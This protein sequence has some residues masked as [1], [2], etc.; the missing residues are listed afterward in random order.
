MMLPGLR[1]RC[2]MPAAWAAA[3]ASA[4]SIGNRRAPDRP[5][6]ARVANARQRLAVHQL[7]HQD[8]ARRRRRSAEP[9]SCSVQMC[10]CVS[11]AMARA[12]RS[13]RSRPLRIAGS[14]ARQNL[15]RHVAIEP[16]VARPVDLAHA[17]GAEQ[18]EHF[19][20][21]SRLRGAACAIAA[22]HR[23]PRSPACSRKP[24]ASGGPRA[25]IRLRRGRPARRARADE[26]TPRARADA[27][28]R[29]ETAPAPATSCPAQSCRP[30]QLA[31]QPC[32]RQRPSRFTVIG[33]DIEDDFAASSTVRPPKKRSSTRRACRGRAR[34][35]FRGR[36]RARG[37]GALAGS[38]DRST[39]VERQRERGAAL[40][41]A[42]RARVIHQQPAHHVR[43]HGKEMRAIL[44][45]HAR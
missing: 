11:S 1:S 22:R 26:R 13:S 45:A 19:E 4:I 24:S 43:R 25:A 32:L 21:P 2:T 38:A 17:A 31:V 30:R 41:R 33:G 15:D 5:A 37:L 3:S 29:R 20:E 23:R 8:T 18:L 36:D 12:S 40:R 7:H 34:R 35:A 6:A 16:R 9:T 44:P 28:S 42:P 27:P 14:V 10:G 39:S